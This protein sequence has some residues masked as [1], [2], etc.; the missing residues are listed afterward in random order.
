MS[1][2]ALVFTAIPSLT[3]II[4]VARAIIWLSR[5]CSTIWLISL[6][7]LFQRSHPVY[8]VV[9]VLVSL[10][11]LILILH[12]AS[13][14]SSWGTIATLWVRTS[15]LAIASLTR[16]V[17]PESHFARLAV[18]AATTVLCLI[19][20]WIGGSL[21][22]SSRSRSSVPISSWIDTSSSV[23]FP[24]GLSRSLS[25]G[26]GFRF[27]VGLSSNLVR[28]LSRW[29]SIGLSTISLIVFDGRSLDN[30]GHGS[31]WFGSLLFSWGNWHLV[32]VRFEDWG[33]L[34]PS[35]DRCRPGSN[36]W[37]WNWSRFGRRI[38]FDRLECWC[39]KRLLCRS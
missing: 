23:A 27:R 21:H 32:F 9:K 35:E 15:L 13:I 22:L 19:S 20:P 29:F 34:G 18:V 10:T 36:L 12:L 26:L 7:I 8:V 17:I 33:R 4:A 1:P 30:R 6:F 28:S 16:T 31:P 24:Y 5:G 38:E 3:L 39:F 11:S 37:E 25:S 14:I 2:L